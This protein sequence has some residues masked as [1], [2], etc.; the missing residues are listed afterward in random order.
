MLPLGICRKHRI[1]HTLYAHSFISP[2]F[3]F[4]SVK[5][6]KLYLAPFKSVEREQARGICYLL[7]NPH[8]PG[9][10]K[11][12]DPSHAAR[13]RLGTTSS[14]GVGHQHLLWAPP[15]L[16]GEPK[17]ENIRAQSLQPSW[18]KARA[19][20]LRAGQEEKC[21]MLKP[22]SRAPQKRVRERYFPAMGLT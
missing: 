2:S 9:Y 19:G 14:S 12:A 16:H 5:T 13:N 6:P 4:C 1:C 8:V 11:R 15:L 18:R 20:F 7:E 21:A 17:P 22:G 10:K 3:L